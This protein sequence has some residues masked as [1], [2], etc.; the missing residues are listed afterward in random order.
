[1][2]LRFGGGAKAVS[3]NAALIGTPVAL[4]GVITTQLVNGAL[5]AQRAEQARETE[6]AQRERDREITQA[7]RCRELEVGN[8][9]ARDD[10]AQAYL[11]QM[12]ALLLDKDRPLRQPAQGKDAR[13]LALARC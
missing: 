11:G 13:I 5:E 3:D 4:G 2:L 7:Q 8:Q 12:A 6:L 9:R 1:M 10:A